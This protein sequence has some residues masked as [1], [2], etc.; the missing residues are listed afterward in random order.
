VTGASERRVE[1]LDFLRGASA[2]AVV[3][4]HVRVTMW[5]GLRAMGAD[6]S[7]LDR[8]AALITLPFPFFGTAV[9]LFFI[10][11]GFAIHYPY[12][13]VDASFA[14]R[15]Y[16][17]RRFLRIYPPYLVAVLATVL[18][19]RG[20][21]AL[22]TV[23]VSP[24]P[25]VAASAV[26]AQNY[27]APA[28]QMIGNPSLWSLPVEVELYIAYPLLYWFWRRAGTARMLLCVALVSA[29]AAGA[30]WAGHDWPMGN[31][32][33]YW[34]IWVSGAVLA[35]QVRRRTLPRWRARYAWLGAAAI[36][37]AAAAR[38]AGVPFGFEHFLWGGIYFL[39]VLWGLNQKAPL[40]RIPAGLVRP[41]LFLGN[42]SYSLYLIHYPLLLAIG[43]WWIGRFG[44]KPVNVVVPLV[45]S[46][47]PIPP[48]YL[49]W[50]FVER[51]LQ[52]WGRTLSHRSHAVVRVPATSQVATG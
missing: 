14:W 51:P 13:A 47:A 25:K 11:S 44:H 7:T 48:A 39:I 22:A 28:G 50:R 45:T 8:A 31:F 40:G 16:V 27:I 37:V 42:I 30:L 29:S 10:V 23:T 12:A 3:L 36:V 38:A 32:A 17:I 2:F 41:V 4:F 20:A 9:M 33:K 21:S 19:E 26:M 5:V 18:A 35:E 6:Y 49:L 24:W 1:W 34:I 52:T 46:L 43:V 15:P